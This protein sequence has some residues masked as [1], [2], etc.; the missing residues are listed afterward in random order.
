MTNA[1]QFIDSVIRSIEPTHKRQNYWCIGCPGFG[2]RVTKSGI[3]SF[4]F[5]Y[6]VTISADKRFSRWVTIG[7]YPEFTI[8]QARREY[9]RLY[10]LV[11]SYGRDPVQEEKEAQ[12]KAA[13]RKTV[14]ELTADYIELGRLK[15]RTYTQEEERYFHRDIW[16]VIGGKYFDE[17]TVADIEAIQH[18]MLKRGKKNKRASQD[19]K[20]AIKNAIAC[21][22]RLFA[23]AI[24]KGLTDYNPVL[25]I[26]PLGYTKVRSR[27]LSFEEIWLFWNRIETLDVLPV[28]AKAMKFLLATMQRSNEVRNMRYAS[29]TF[30]DAMWQMEWNETKNRTMHRVPLNRYALELIEDVRPFTEASEYIFGGTKAR[31]PLKIPNPD[32]KP[33]CITSFPQA[34]R[35]NRQALGIQDFRKYTPRLL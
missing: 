18:N 32:L 34:I 25:N 9:D 29:V 22:R 35:R 17:V 26:E 23:L 8:R 4:V 7:N 20:T 11:H 14:R 1:V 13:R 28:P 3:K 6:M 33:M 30:D 10:D 15:G 31:K 12:A 16:P 5:K 2:L 24:K 19:G 21:V 27:V